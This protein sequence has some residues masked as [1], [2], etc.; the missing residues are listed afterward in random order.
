MFYMIL[1]NLL[2]NSLYNSISINV[3]INHIDCL[4][5]SAREQLSDQNSSELLTVWR[6]VIEMWQLSD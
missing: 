6:V 5:E 4:H 3:I 1:A 2:A